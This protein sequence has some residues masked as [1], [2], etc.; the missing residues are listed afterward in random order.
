M[1]FLHG[2]LVLCYI[3]H[4][5]VCMN[6]FMLYVDRFLAEWI[7]LPNSKFRI[8]WNI[9][10]LMSI[11]I[12]LNLYIF[13]A[14]FKGYYRQNSFG[15]TNAAHLRLFTYYCLDFLFVVDIFISMKMADYVHMHSGELLGHVCH[16]RVTG[17]S[18][19][20]SQS[21]IQKYFYF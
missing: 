15:T 19:R 21:L 20:V 17:C 14:A 5:Y 11:Y 18:I 4:T 6:Y 7:I 2:D 10:M 12:V 3:Q 13:E 8:V 9:V 16:I 1:A